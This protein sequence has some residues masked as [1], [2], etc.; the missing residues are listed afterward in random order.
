MVCFLFSVTV[1]AASEGPFGFEIKLFDDMGNELPGTFPVI[2]NKDGTN[3]YESD[4]EFGDVVYIHS[5]ESMYVCGVPDGSRY[6][7]KEVDS[8]FGYE[9]VGSNVM[10]GVVSDDSIADVVFTNTHVSVGPKMPE[11]GGSGLFY[12][13]VIGTGLIILGICLFKYRKQTLSLFLVLCV[14][15]LCFSV[16]SKAIEDDAGGFYPMMSLGHRSLIH[17]V[18]FS[19][20]EL[21]VITP[22]EPSTIYQGS[23]EAGYSSTFTEGLYSLSLS[24]WCRGGDLDVSFRVNNLALPFYSKL[25]VYNNFVDAE[26]NTVNF[27]APFREC[28]FEMLGSSSG[29]MG[30]ELPAEYASVGRSQ[31]LFNY[32]VEGDGNFDFK[33]SFSSG[34]TLGLLLPELERY[35]YKAAVTF[36]FETVQEHNVVD[37]IWGVWGMRV[38]YNDGYISYVSPGRVGISPRWFTAFTTQGFEIELKDDRSIRV[39]KNV[40]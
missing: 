26:S 21:D 5:D 39:T 29:K 22:M 35:D 9:S 36:L 2:V 8:G 14:T 38:V 37:A 20:G 31:V 16:E 3:R 10:T 24:D 34:D 1:S 12:F 13:I 19:S 28:K 18:D 11:T 6:E 15:L 4:I 27:M 32:F 25:T 33:L 17:D 7:I 30:F 23:A 40:V